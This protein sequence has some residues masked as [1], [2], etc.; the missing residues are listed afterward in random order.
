M[1]VLN[2]VIW[3][4]FYLL[5]T[6]VYIGNVK[7]TI[8]GDPMPREQIEYIVLRTDSFCAERHGSRVVE[9]AIR[10]N[11]KDKIMGVAYQCS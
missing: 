5:S 4:V 2:R 11:A 8:E 10:N 6:V 9:V 1:M 7:V 3:A